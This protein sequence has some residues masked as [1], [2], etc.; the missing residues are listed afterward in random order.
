MYVKNEQ[1]LINEKFISKLA[2]FNAESSIFTLEINYKRY[3]FRFQSVVFAAFK[4]KG[5]LK[6]MNA[7]RGLFG[8]EMVV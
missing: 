2:K 6:S 4:E 7:D 1:N 5:F 8:F 3:T